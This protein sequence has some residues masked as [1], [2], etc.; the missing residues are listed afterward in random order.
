[1]TDDRYT[2]FPAGFFERTDESDDGLFYAQP[3]IVTHIDDGAIAAVGRIYAELGLGEGH[4]LDLMSSWI[5][6]FPVR[7]K[8]LVAH[9][10][11]RFELGRNEAAI[12]A[13]QADLNRHQTLPFASNS[14]D[15]AVCCVSV[16]Y[17][18][19]PFE[20]FDEVARVVKPEG[21][22]CCT[23]SNRCFPTK[24]IRG[25]LS[26]DEEMRVN[27]VGGY[28]ARSGWERVSARLVTEPG[29]GGDPLFA[30]WGHAAA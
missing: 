25:W 9:G 21:I 6:H 14:F 24:A 8:A 1:M 3:R 27:L 4:V 15:A 18:N 10:M 20:V 19:Q 7:P 28:F 17:L 22:F 12:G 5:S 13:V 11:N 30:V 23:F 2:G 16:D 26:I 29:R